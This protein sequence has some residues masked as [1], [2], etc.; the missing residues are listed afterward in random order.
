MTSWQQQRQV[1]NNTVCQQT[2][3]SDDAELEITSLSI[4]SS[5]LEYL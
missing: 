3:H 2:K 1:V 4:C 5:V